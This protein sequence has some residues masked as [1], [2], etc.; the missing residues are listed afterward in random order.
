[1]NA[2]TQMNAR[3]KCVEGELVSTTRYVGVMYGLFR[4]RTQEWFEGK[5]ASAHGGKNEYAQNG[6]VRCIKKQKA[7]LK[8][9]ESLLV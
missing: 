7:Y 9:A 6:T 3:K 1:M 2:L 4:F 5:A 8:A